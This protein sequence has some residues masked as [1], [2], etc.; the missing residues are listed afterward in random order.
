MRGIQGSITGSALEKLNAGSDTTP[1][2]ADRRMF[3]EAAL[4]RLK[5]G[6]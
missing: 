3:I 1:Q 4:R 5:P 2:S 6:T